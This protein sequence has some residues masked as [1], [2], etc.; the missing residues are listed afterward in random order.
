MTLLFSEK[1]H[2]YF[3]KEAPEIKLTSVSKIIERYHEKFDVEKIAATYAAKK[4]KSVEEVKEEW[5]KINGDAIKRGHAY[6][7]Y[8]EEKF[9]KDAKKHGFVVH[10]HESEEDTQYKKALDILNL[11]PGIYPELILYI[12][13][14]GVV[15]TSDYVEIFDDGTCTVG[16]FKTNKKLEFEGFPVWDDK[17]K[18]KKPK[19]MFAPISHIDD[20]NGMHYSIQLS[21]YAY[22]LEEAGYR[23]RPGGLEIQHIL[24]DTNDEPVDTV[25]YP[26]NYL[27]KE[28]KSLLEHFYK[29]IQ[30]N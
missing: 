30:T 20:C 24:F 16:D 3:Y 6:H 8:R 7:T 15:G 21:L 28:V 12:P 1:D 14:Y 9:L 13:K 22:M 27:K 2:R 10:Q 25:T 5:A 23:L 18:S 11:K 26:I 29:T 4:K 19:K 17:T